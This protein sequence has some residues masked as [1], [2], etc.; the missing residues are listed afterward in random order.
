MLRVHWSYMSQLG[1]ERWVKFH[2]IILF[3][4]VQT[5]KDSIPRGNQELCTILAHFQCHA[6]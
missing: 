3:F 6:Y 2:K 4:L 5:E 1:F